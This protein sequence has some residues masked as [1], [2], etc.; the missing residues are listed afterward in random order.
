MAIL[1]F[2]EW[3]EIHG[4]EDC[5]GCEYNIIQSARCTYK[6]KCVLYDRY[7]KQQNEK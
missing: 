6:G 2:E 1:T 5:T 3:L 7:I 4:D